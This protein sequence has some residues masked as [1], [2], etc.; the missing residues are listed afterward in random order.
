MLPIRLRVKQNLM[1]MY[2]NPRDKGVPNGMSRSR[3]VWRPMALAIMVTK[4]P[5][6]MRRFGFSMALSKFARIKGARFTGRPWE[7]Q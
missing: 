2:R 4:S 1:S 7:A 3:W 5:M 6:Q